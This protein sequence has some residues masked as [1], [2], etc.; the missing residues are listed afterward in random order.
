VAAGGSLRSAATFFPGL[1]FGWLRERTGS[2]FPPI[3]AH[4]AANIVVTA[5]E[6]RS[7]IL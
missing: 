7:T 4:V 6:G 1:L 2:I 5:F 3:L